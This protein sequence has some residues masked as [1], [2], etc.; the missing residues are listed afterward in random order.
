MKIIVTGGCGFIGSH[1]VDELVNGNHEV[2]VIDNQSANNDVFYINSNAKYFNCDINDFITH[3][4]N[5]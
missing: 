3:T 5:I 4:K 1:I 2:L